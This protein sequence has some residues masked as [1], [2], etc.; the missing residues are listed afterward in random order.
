MY[1]PYASLDKFIIALLLATAPL[2]VDAR[3]TTTALAVGT[4][5]A[6]IA[7]QLPASAAVLASVLTPAIAVPTWP[8]VC[9]LW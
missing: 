3:L 8:F 9:V 4:V 6:W 7:L 5:I 1:K 2:A